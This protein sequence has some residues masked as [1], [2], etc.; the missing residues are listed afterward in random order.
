[1]EQFSLVLFTILAQCAA[2]LFFTVGLVQLCSPGSP[3]GREIS[4]LNRGYLFAL[5]MLG[6]A[7]VVAGIHFW[8]AGQTNHVIHSLTQGS[9]LT[10][11]MTSLGAFGAV[12]LPVNIV[13]RKSSENT[14]LGNGLIVIGMV[15]AAWLIKAVADVLT[16]PTAP[17]WSNSLTAVLFYQSALACGTSMAALLFLGNDQSLGELQLVARKVIGWLG[18]A[19]IVLLA[20]GAMMLLVRLVE[21]GTIHAMGDSHALPIYLHAALVLAG[22]LAWVAPAIR[23]TNARCSALLGTV[24]VVVGEVMERIY[25]YDLLD[26]AAAH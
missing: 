20:Y 1:M 19:S 11:E 24:L 25:F 18:F 12:L 3:Q 4:S 5:V 21:A 17:A 2:G 7:L 8:Q 10:V 16:M 26:V 14:G 6:L 15:I 9:A 22:L 13:Q 23:G